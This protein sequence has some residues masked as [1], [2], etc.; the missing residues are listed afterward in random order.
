MVLR[1]IYISIAPTVPVRAHCTG[2]HRC[3]IAAAAGDHPLSRA[4]PTH[5]LCQDRYSRHPS[6][7]PAQSEACR[8]AA[9]AR[10]VRPRELP[11]EPDDT[12]T[13]HDL[14][15]A[16]SGGELLGNVQKLMLEIALSPQCA[17]RTARRRGRC[18]VL[19]REPDWPAPRYE[20]QSDRRELISF[21]TSAGFRCGPK[22]KPAAA[23]SPAPA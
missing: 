21:M 4:P 18:G 6:Q 23:T 5:R 16:K 10:H 19:S 1:L 22:P 2:P 14:E 3:A 15:V 7:S 13:G 11:A 9:C 17:L 20:G 12:A 8:P